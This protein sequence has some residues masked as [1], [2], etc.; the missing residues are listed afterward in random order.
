MPH[1]GSRRNASS[2]IL[3]RILGPING[4]QSGV[5]YVSVAEEADAKHP[6][7]RVAN[8]Y[9]RR[10]YKVIQTA[11][12]AICNSSPD[13]PARAGWGPVEPLGPMDES[14]EGS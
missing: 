2:A 5:S 1:H 6:S 3:D 13:A 14:D 11:G 9:A 8:A 4:G 12:R 7:P 10:G